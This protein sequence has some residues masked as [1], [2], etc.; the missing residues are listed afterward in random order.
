MP[1]NTI[2]R[3][4]FSLIRTLIV[5]LAVLI[6]GAGGV[7]VM[8]N[9]DIKNEI[10]GDG[11]S[12]QEESNETADWKI[13]QEPLH[14]FEM[15]IPSEYSW[16]NPY[17]GFQQETYA[18]SFFTKD[19]SKIDFSIEVSKV[20]EAGINGE[21]IS[22]VDNIEGDDGSKLNGTVLLGG[23]TAYVFSAGV[24]I[25][26]GEPTR[27]YVYVQ[28]CYNDLLYKLTFLNTQTIED[29]DKLILSTFKFDVKN[30]DVSAQENSEETAN[31][32]SEISTEDWETYQNEE[33]GFETKYPLN[34]R[35]KEK[36]SE[37]RTFY[38]EFC[39]LFKEGCDDYQTIKFLTFEN[40]KKQCIANSTKQED[41]EFWSFF[42]YCVNDNNSVLSQQIDYM[43]RIGEGNIDDDFIKKLKNKEIWLEIFNTA[44]VTEFG[45][46][47]KVNINGINGLKFYGWSGQGPTP[48]ILFYRVLLIKDNSLVVLDFKP[49]ENGDY[50]SDKYE[51]EYNPFYSNQDKFIDA[52]F[53]AVRNNKIRKWDFE[54]ADRMDLFN[55]ILSTF[56][57][58]DNETS[59]WKT[60]RNEELG[61]E[62]KLPSYISVDLVLNDEYNR[63][64][65]FKGDEE[66]FEV[67]L[68]DGKTMSLDQYY[69]LDFPISGK[70]TLGGNE[71]LVFEASNGYCDGPG[72]GNPFIAYSTK[73][74]DD[75]YNL[76]FYGDAQL[77]D[78][79]KTILSSFKFINPNSSQQNNIP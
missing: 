45:D 73:Y 36:L 74:N 30:D 41:S 60:Y 11:I 53:N 10:K 24:G 8:K 4:G 3:N 23:D 47:E 40:F 78:T 5:V 6:I 7:Y 52:Y 79:E 68:K 66:N 71:A 13:F 43:N 33:Y 69:Y 67:R 64:V 61:F 72:C 14:N 56:K 70:S 18:R 35:L 38:L 15:K 46:I 12:V 2:T 29:D 17:E 63:L 9:H 25:S 27:P 31:S 20:P 49:I 32:H 75:F 51:K 21:L 42:G 44:A 39:D 54:I 1:T 19:K 28:R 26:H 62:L 76:V 59:D 50:L 37:P 77:S 48:D 34:I 16:W 65:V 57:F 55:Q 58:I 22:C